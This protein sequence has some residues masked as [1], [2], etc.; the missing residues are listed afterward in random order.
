MSGCAAAGSTRSTWSGEWSRAGGPAVAA[1]RCR[2]R[3]WCAARS[4]RIPAGCWWSRTRRNWSRGCSPRWPAITPS[5]R[6]PE[7]ATCTRRWPGRSAATGP[8]PRWRCCPRCTAG[9]AARPPSCWPCCGGASPGPT[10]TWKPP[11]ARGRRAGWSGPGSAGPARRRPPSGGAS[12]R[13]R[14]SRAPV[15]SRPGARCGPAAASPG[16]SWCRPA[17]PTG[18]WSCWPAC[19]AGSPRWPARPDPWMA[20]GWSSSSTTR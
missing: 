3:G 20:P 12:P 9:R 8:R 16:T 18:P 4:L 5:R 14:M 15:T 2:F 6:R 11:P 10:L 17:R 1:A 7:P 13:R 19:A